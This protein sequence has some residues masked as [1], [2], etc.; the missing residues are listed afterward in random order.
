MVDRVYHY[1]IVQQEIILRDSALL[2]FDIKMEKRAVVVGGTSGIGREVVRILIREGWKVGVA[3]RREELL[4][5]LEEEYPEHVVTEV[6]DVTHADAVDRLH[7]LVDKL[8]GMD[9]FL[10]S[11]GAGSQNRNLER[12]IE[13]RTVMTNVYKFT[14]IINTFARRSRECSQSPREAA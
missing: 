3:G 14:I 4:K 2:G 12:E 1:D 9:L 13:E 7:I 8:G 5:S 10:L 11:S 6:I